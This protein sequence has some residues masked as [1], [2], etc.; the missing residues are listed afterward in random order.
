[1]SMV[2]VSVC[3][4]KVHFQSTAQTGPRTEICLVVSQDAYILILNNLNTIEATAAI[5]NS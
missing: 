2:R 1:M 3:R 5:G 4:D